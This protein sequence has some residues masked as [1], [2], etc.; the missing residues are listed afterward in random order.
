[1][2]AINTKEAALPEDAAPDTG[3]N[4]GKTCFLSQVLQGTHKHLLRDGSII[5]LAQFVLLAVLLTADKGPILDPLLQ[6]FLLFYASYT[7]WAMFEKER[8]EG[9]EEYM[10]SLPVSRTRLFFIKF[11]P[12]A[13]VVSLVLAFYL[14][15]H[16][17]FD[18]PFILD[19]VS[20]SITYAIFFFVSL[21]FSLSIKNFITVFLLTSLLSIGQAFCIKM[22]LDRT[23]TDTEALFRANASL[24]VF[25]I[26]FF[27]LFQVYDIKPLSY[28]N[29]KFAPPAC[30]LVFIIAGTA[31]L[32][33]GETWNIYSLT[34]GG[35]VI[36][37]KCTKTE[38]LNK[39][40]EEVKRFKYK[41]CVFPLYEV[42]QENFLYA[43]RR[44][45]DDNKGCW[46]SSLIT[47]DLESGDE[48]QL[49]DLPE[50][51][52][53][54]GSSPGKIG[55]IIDGTY[56]VVLQ[57]YERQLQMVIGISGENVKQIPISGILHEQYI[58]EFFHISHPPL[59]FY[60][61]TRS[62]LV[63]RI[64]ETGAAEKLFAA[65]ALA[66]WKDKMLV[67]DKT[68][69]TLYKIS[70]G[71]LTPIYR[72]TGKIQKMLRRFAAHETRLV[73]FKKGKEY[74]MLDLEKDEE[75][76]KIN[77]KFPPFY[78][79]VQ[80]DKYILFNNRPQEIVISEIKNGKV[81][82]KAKWQPEIEFEYE[83][84]YVSSHGFMVFNEKEYEVYPF[85]K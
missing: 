59:R 21:A 44:N 39:Q 15:L 19:N 7:G 50:G 66:T 45:R 65:E 42:E 33:T 29:R 36:R 68:G 64:D 10:L 38:I 31:L 1:M 12:R 73:I 46:L 67:F 11:L 9:A 25:P 35:S 78:Y 37:S 16:H 79:L 69:M 27:I 85:K 77:L 14:L 13:A 47:V 76:E 57:S 43:V 24:L 48:Q 52:S 28:F 63:Y 6:I 51:W 17:L 32:T 82:E 60:I 62:K 84:I 80:D 72:E 81:I 18:F 61:I 56:Y 83:Q 5:L 3:R 54:D 30:L 22:F 75:P 58:S 34:S 41:G 26:L 74:F 49:F 55:K 2:A 53:L 8:Q 23:L 70:E 4:E 20:F 71:S 40:A